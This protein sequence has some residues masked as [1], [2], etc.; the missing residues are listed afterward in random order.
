MDIKWMMD[1]LVDFCNK[2]DDIKFSDSVVEN[3]PTIN[4]IQDLK[5][6]EWS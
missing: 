3:R 4:I 1:M 6:V 2:K 5:M